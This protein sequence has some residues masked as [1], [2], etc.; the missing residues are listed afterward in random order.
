MEDQYRVI[1]SLLQTEKGTALQVLNKYLFEVNKKANKVDIRRA[2]EKIYQ[3]KVK[4]VN[5]SLSHGKKKR[6]R[7]VQ[8]R[9]PDWK[10]AIVT[11][12]KGHKIEG[13]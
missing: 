6:V 13:V 1:K 2:V 9:A 11:L 7:Y 8:G 12:Q 3:V 5:T 10:K 4:S